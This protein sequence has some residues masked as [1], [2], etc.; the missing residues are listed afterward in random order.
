[1]KNIR[2]RVKRSYVEE[3]KKLKERGK[4]KQYFRLREEMDKIFPQKHLDE[5][6][7]IPIKKMSK[8]Y[9]EVKRK[10][11]QKEKEL[12]R[13]RNFVEAIT[14]GKIRKE[15]IGRGSVFIV[16]RVKELYHGDAI[17]VKI[18]DL[19]IEKSPKIE[20]FSDDVFKKASEFAKQEI[21]AHKEY[22]KILGDRVA[23]RYMTQIILPK[24]SK[25]RGAKIFIA[26][27][28]V[29][30]FER[31]KPLIA[32]RFKEVNGNWIRDGRE[33]IDVKTLEKLV[34]EIVKINY[35]LAKHGLLADAHLSN[36]GLRLDSKKLVLLDTA[37]IG[38]NEHALTTSTVLL[39]SSIFL[40]YDKKTAVKMRKKA[41]KELKKL[42]ENEKDAKLKEKFKEEMKMW[43]NKV[44]V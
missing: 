12:K 10:E 5:Y 22:E 37:H 6:V 3:L 18:R 11:R 41:L 16:K 39:L 24:E 42:I 19:G 35:E 9:F 23:R 31:V 28:E 13:I 26:P 17:V 43:K 33:K 21:K 44:K 30:V 4:A 25:R 20:F 29:H 15:P 38:K 8:E 2:K 27:R 36:Y 40:E 14:G 34:P 32:E 1:M 7:E